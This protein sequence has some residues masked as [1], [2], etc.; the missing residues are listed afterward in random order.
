MGF[1][2]RVRVFILYILF[3]TPHWI[4]L[5]L[6]SLVG[7]VKKHFSLS[8]SEIMGVVSSIFSLLGIAILFR[9]FKLGLMNKT[10]L[11]CFPIY[12]CWHCTWSDIVISKNQFFP[13]E[14]KEI[15]KLRNAFTLQYRWEKVSFDSKIAQLMIIVLILS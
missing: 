8:I 7:K 3:R 14:K 9:F 6:A 11:S 1:L 4:C 15:T 2:N 12:T 10:I 13:N 5:L